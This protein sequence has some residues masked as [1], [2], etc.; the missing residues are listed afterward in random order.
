MKSNNTQKT[1]D[2]SCAVISVIFACKAKEAI[3]SVLT[4]RAAL[5]EQSRSRERCVRWRHAAAAVQTIRDSLKFAKKL[6]DLSIVTF[7]GKS[8]LGGLKSR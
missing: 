8:S 5:T 1:K 3:I 2:N 6:L 7:F 4:K